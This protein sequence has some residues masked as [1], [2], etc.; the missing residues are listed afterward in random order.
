MTNVTSNPTATQTAVTTAPVV[1]VITLSEMV[2]MLMEIRGAKAIT[3]T[4]DTSMSKTGKMRKT[5]NPFYGDCF[6]WQSVNGMVNFR[7]DEGV[8]RRL[9]KEGKTADEFD[10]GES[11]HE[12]IVRADGTIT[13]FLRHKKDPRKV[14]LRFMLINAGEVR[15]H[16]AAD[17]TINAD[18][19][20]PYL[21]PRSDYANQGL[22]KPL[23]FQA[24]GIDDIRTVTVNGE[25]FAIVGD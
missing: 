9:A 17:D 13:P 21:P 18:E 8:L 16:N 24:W 25:T 4:H 22:D 7:Y 3:F 10:K 20:K 11:W 14:Y 5:G 19:L 2:R 12:A 15:Y 6:K 1:K 23:I